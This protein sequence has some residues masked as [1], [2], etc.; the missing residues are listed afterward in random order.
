MRAATR[1]TIVVTSLL[2]ALLVAAAGA[3]AACGSSGPSGASAGQDGG[4]S[5]ATTR[6]ADAGDAM[7]A[8]AGAGDASSDAPASLDAGVPHT[9]KFPVK[10]VVF[11][12]K[13]N[14]TFDIYFGKFPGANGAT[15]GTLCNGQTFPLQPMLD[16]SSPD[17]THAWAAALESYNDGGMNCFDQ[18]TTARYPGDGGPLGYQ[19][20]DEQDIPNYWALARSFV[21][22]DN[23]YSALHGPSFPNH[24]YTIAA[25]SGGVTDN[26]LAAVAANPPAPQAGACT[27]STSCPDPGEAGLE[28]SNVAPYTVKT[29]IWGCDADPKVRV[30]ILDEEGEIEDIYPCLDMQTLGDE[31]TAAGVSWKMY[32][33]TEGTLDGGFQNSG[34]YIW[35]VY[36][37]I[38]HMR[39][40]PAWAQHVVPVTDFV[41]D[42]MNG[43]LPSVSWIST[44]TVV[45]EHTPQ[46]VCT[47]ENWSVSLLQALAAGPLWGS[48]AVFL[49]WDDF[50][51]FY[52]HVPP[53]QLDAFGLG[54]RVPLLVVSPFAKAGT[55]DHTR[56][57]FSSVLKFI[58]A[59]FDLPPLTARD[60]SAVDMTQ[61][62]DFTQ[63]PLPLPALQQR[64]TSPNADAGC[65]MY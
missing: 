30:P 48:S 9:A 3:V 43:T 22:S 56:A 64:A 29:G 16:R 17:I 59:D 38:R 63:T 47:G 45:S 6:G 54:F 35:T 24:L 50:G 2:V 53:V 46:S 26:P 36:D 42:A 31:L 28:P 55:I 49:T 62:F 25:T 1:I 52:D 12:V 19:V 39:D 60:E 51:G 27:S 8:E 61:D 23:F 4:A 40:S 58:E 32:A 14:R 65:G 21:L 34:G 18:I 10:H 44:P 20:A 13:E 11:F 41:T 33:P 37:A 57:E 5:D 15:T 7:T